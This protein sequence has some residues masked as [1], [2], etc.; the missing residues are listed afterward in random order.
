MPAPS[1]RTRTSRSSTSGSPASVTGR[2][3]GTSS[4]TGAASGGSREGR[5][6]TDAAE[7]PDKGGNHEGEDL[8]DRRSRHPGHRDR[9]VAAGHAGA[10]P[11]QVDLHPAVGL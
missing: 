9:G 1:A 6:P 4:I 7:T 2:A 10:G 8:L 3:T 5:R 11:G